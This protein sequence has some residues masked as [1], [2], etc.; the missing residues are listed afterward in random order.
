MNMRNFSVIK[1][2]KRASIK[3]ENLHPWIFDNEI[4]EIKG[5]YKNGDLVD[6][7]NYKDK[8]VGTGYI[9]DN[10]KIRVRIISRNTNDKFDD[11]F[12]ERRARYA[13]KYRY[14]LLND[15][16]SCRLIFG[17]ADSFSGLTIDKYNGILVTEINSLCMENKKE[18]IYNLVIKVLNEYGYEIDGIFERCDSAIRV[19]EGLELYSGFYEKYKK[20]NYKSTVIDLDGIKYIINFES[21]QKTGFFLDQRFNRLAIRNI[22]KDKNVLDVCTCTGSFGLNAYLGGAKRVV[23]VDISSSALE[24]AKENAKLNEFNIEYVESDAFAYLDTI[25][26]GE[27]D[28]IILDPPAFTKSHEKIENAK[29][30]YE[31]LNYKAIKK[32]ERGSYLATCSC[33]SFMREDMFLET[34]NEAARKSGVELKLVEAR[35][36]SLDHPILLN[37]PETYYL[38]F[39]IFQIV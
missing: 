31:E 32:L 17:E 24:I 13:I 28:L 15:L 36:Q 21:G 10:S 25:K 27:F 3:E 5:E 11:D 20:P 29:K 7:V 26:K 33:S 8:Y 23:S 19:K 30:G 39:L 2:N 34:I 12:F 38:K 35:R 37:V 6:V 9:N 16:S 4:D 1:I 14:D 18:L 22:S